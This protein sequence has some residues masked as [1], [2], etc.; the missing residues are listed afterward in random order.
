VSIAERV[1]RGLEWMKTEGH[2]Y[3]VNPNR[4][5]PALLNMGS[6][7][8]CPLGQAGS[9]MT[10]Y[11]VVRRVFPDLN[12]YERACAGGHSLRADCLGA[13]HCTRWAVDHGFMWGSCGEAARQEQAEL[14]AEWERVLRLHLAAII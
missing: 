13:P 14:Q 1:A 5:V 9:P 4:I 2:R 10:F 11:G 8:S 6:V 7:L 3:Q 12:D